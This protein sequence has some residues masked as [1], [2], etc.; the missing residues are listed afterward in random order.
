MSD[1]PVTT[2]GQIFPFMRLPYELRHKIYRFAAVRPDGYIGQADKRGRECI[3][4]KLQATFQALIPHTVFDKIHA[5]TN[6]IHPDHE[7]KQ[8]AKDFRIYGCLNLAGVCRQMHEELTTV[9]FESNGFELRDAS[10]FIAF[11]VEIQPV[12]TNLIRDIRIYHTITLNMEDIE[13]IFGQF[14]GVS[15][16]TFY[17]LLEDN[18]LDQETSCS[19][20]LHVLKALRSFNNLQHFDLAYRLEVPAKYFHI[21]NPMNA[22]YIIKHADSWRGQPMQW[23]LHTKNVLQKLRQ[24]RKARQE[25]PIAVEVE[26]LETNDLTNEVATASGCEQLFFDVYADAMV[27]ACLSHAEECIEDIIQNRNRQAP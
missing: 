17:C 3:I 14:G 6:C 23:D 24:D 10:A 26:Q 8:L 2:H 15:W 13:A 7:K 20:L 22:N 12:R 21:W 18:Y 11:V 25:Q 27:D 16:E 4:G 1:T 5:P 19:A 9:F